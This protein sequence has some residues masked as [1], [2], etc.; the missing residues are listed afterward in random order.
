MAELPAGLVLAGFFLG[1]DPAELLAAS[2]PGTLGAV[3]GLFSS[4][5][6]SR[7]LFVLCIFFALLVDPLV[8]EVKRVQAVSKEELIARQI[9]GEEVYVSGH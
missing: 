7:C 8:V 6:S 5:D 4:H 1:E 2:R 3:L 9:R